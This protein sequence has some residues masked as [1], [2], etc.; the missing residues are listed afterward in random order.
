MLKCWLIMSIIKGVLLQEGFGRALMLGIV[1]FRP[2]RDSALRNPV[3]F[4]PT[5]SNSSSWNQ[6]GGK[7]GR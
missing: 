4:V 2:F 1:L 7:D 3:R 5:S 6:T